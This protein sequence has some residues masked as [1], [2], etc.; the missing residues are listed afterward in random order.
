MI[1]NNIFNLLGIFILVFVGCGLISAGLN[2][3]VDKNFINHNQGEFIWTYIPILILFICGIIVLPYET[4]L[5]L[6]VTRADVIHFWTVPSLEI[7]VET[8]YINYYHFFR[9]IDPNPI[10]VPPVDIVADAI[11]RGN[12]APVVA[13]AA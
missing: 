13:P 6:L 9:G 3:I 4:L 5:K 2:I 10:P 1:L 12:G 7:P 8:P 11:D